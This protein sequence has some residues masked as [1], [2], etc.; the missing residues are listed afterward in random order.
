VGGQHAQ[1][2]ICYIVL[3]LANQAIA[4]DERAKLESKPARKADFP[5]RAPWHPPQF[6]IAEVANT[7]TQGNA[8]NDG[9]VSASSLS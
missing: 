8:G 7:L 4:M 9:A 6:F 3:A 2:Y 1:E 5:P